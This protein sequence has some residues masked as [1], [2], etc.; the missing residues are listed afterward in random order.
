[1]TSK[2]F[3]EHVESF[4]FAALLNWA[5]DVETYIKVIESSSAVEGLVSS[6]EDEDGE[7][8]LFDRL[9]NLSEYLVDIRHPHPYDDAMAVYLWL[10]AKKCSPLTKDAISII[11]GLKN[12]PHASKVVDHLKRQDSCYRSF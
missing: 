8:F 9:L 6:F 2:D 4:D 11:E 12:V 1:M 10:L 3:F 5:A 7:Y